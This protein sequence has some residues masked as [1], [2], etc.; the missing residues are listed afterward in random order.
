MRG[1]VNY[2]FILFL[3]SLPPYKSILIS[4]PFWALAISHF[5]NV[6][7]LYLLLTGGPK[8]VSEVLGFK[9]EH[10]GI[11]AALPYLARLIFGFVF[12]TIGDLIRKRE[13]MTTTSIRKTFM[14]FCTL[15]AK[16]KNEDIFHGH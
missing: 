14:I 12:A 3:Q 13:L 16:H 4:V 2:Y 1:Y 7:G 15:F 6:W 8:F 9:L 11:L 5:G 10:S